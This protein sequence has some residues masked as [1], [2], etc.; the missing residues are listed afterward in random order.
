MW[1]ISYNSITEIKNVSTATSLSGSSRFRM[2][3]SELIEKKVY[4]SHTEIEGNIARDYRL[5]QKTCEAWG[6]NY[7]VNRLMEMDDRG[8]FTA[9]RIKRYRLFA[10]A[11]H[12]KKRVERRTYRLNKSKVRKKLTAL[13]RLQASRKFIAFYSISFPE[14]APD[15]VLYKV[16]NSFLTNCRTRRGLKTYAWVAERQRNGTLHFHMLTPNFM[17]IKEV[18]R[19]MA[20]AINTAVKQG[21]MS[22]GSSSFERYNGV[23]VDSPQR[24]KRRQGETRK[25][26]RERL[27]RASKGNVSDRMRWIAGYLV[28]YVT[29]N[30]VEFNHLPYHSSRDV[31]ALF[32]SQ[33]RN[34]DNID[35]LMQY[36]SDDVADYKIYSD[37][38][39]TCYISK[40]FIDDD[41]FKEI[42]GINELVY[43]ISNS[44]KKRK[45]KLIE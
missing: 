15:K 6:M 45:D 13:C 34:D 42:D 4:R 20:S 31:S 37:E 19:A 17:Q 14:Q 5:A 7:D 2:L 3:G 22:W 1:S 43:N 23:D 29:K 41:M 40:V 24:P 36:A 12:N 10:D 11:L 21:L 9:Q 32:T 25:Q 18:N 39:I 26:Y 16:F 27:R 38:K 30:E 8:I 33:L 28:K 35:D 44:N